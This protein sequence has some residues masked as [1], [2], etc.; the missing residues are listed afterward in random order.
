MPHHHRI[1]RAQGRDKPADSE[2]PLFKWAR[3]DS[4]DPIF[5][6]ARADAEDPLFK[7]ARGEPPQYR[8]HRVAR[9]QGHDTPANAE[10]PMF[11]W[12][13]ASRRRR[14]NFQMGKG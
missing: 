1:A 3:A 5:K 12:A 13:R 11:K 14:S 8:H 7:W 10:D 6:W 9:A 4:E 2:D